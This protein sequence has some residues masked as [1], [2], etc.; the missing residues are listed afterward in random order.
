MV[1]ISKSHKGIV[2][3]AQTHPKGHRR[4]QWL[5]VPEF[6]GAIVTIEP[7]KV[8]WVV[9]RAAYRKNYREK[10]NEHARHSAQTSTL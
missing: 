8:P 7:N 5:A 9:R 3:F 6:S 2:Y 1:F 10:Q 4:L